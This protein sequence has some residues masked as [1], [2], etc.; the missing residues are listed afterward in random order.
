M[1]SITRPVDIFEYHSSLIDSHNEQIDHTGYGYSHGNHD[2]SKQT[3]SVLDDDL[4]LKAVSR[5]PQRRNSNIIG[6]KFHNLFD[7]L[8]RRSRRSSFND[9][10]HNN[11]NLK[12][13]GHGGGHGNVLADHND[14]LKQSGHGGG[15][16]NVL[17]DHNDNLKQSGHGGGHGNVLAD[18][19]D[20]LKQSGHGGG[21][22][23]VLADHN[24]NL[25]QSGHGGGHGNVLADHND[26]LKQSGPGG[27]HG[28]ILTDHNDNLKQSGHG[29]GHGNVLA[30]HNDNLKQ[31]GH[32]G[33][34][35][36]VL[37]DHSDN[38]KQSGHGGG[39][40]NVLA[41]HNGD[42]MQSGLKIIES[43]YNSSNNIDSNDN[44]SPE[45]E[46]D[47]IFN[48]VQAQ[49][50][51]VE[52]I[53]K[54]KGSSSFRRQPRFDEGDMEKVPD[55]LQVPV[56]VIEDV[57]EILVDQ[58]ET[59][60]LSDS[61]SDESILSDNQSNDKKEMDCV[62]TS[63]SNEE[64]ANNNRSNQSTTSDN[65]SDAGTSSNNQSNSATNRPDQ[66]NNNEKKEDAPP[67]QSKDSNFPTIQSHKGCLPNS[68]SNNI[69]NQTIQS[70]DDIHATDQ[71]DHE[72][73]EVDVLVNRTWDTINVSI[74][75]FLEKYQNL[76]KRPSTEWKTI[77]I[78]ISSTFTDFFVEREII[79]KRIMPEL[80]EWADK[81][82]VRIVECDLRWGVPANTD[83]KET[84]GIMMD[85]LDRCIEETNG[86]PFFVCLLGDRYGWVPTRKYVSQ[87]IINQFDWVYPTSMT[88]MEIIHGALRTNSQNALF[89]MREPSSLEGIPESYQPLYRDRSLLAKQSIKRLKSEL[90]N[91]FPGQ[92]FDYSS[93][94]AGVDKLT[95]KVAF[96]HLEDF[97]E[98]VIK[99][100]KEK[101]HDYIKENFE[102]E[103]EC[104]TTSQDIFIQKRGEFLLGR[105]KELRMLQEFSD[106]EMCDDDLDA[107]QRVLFVVAPSGMGKSSLMARYVQQ[108]QKD[109]I[110]CAWNFTSSSQ[111]T[112]SS[113]SVLQ[114]L[115]ETLG[116]ILKVKLPQTGDQLIHDY[117]ALKNYF[118]K[119]LKEISKKHPGFIIIIDAINQFKDNWGRSG[120]WLP[121]PSDELNIKYVISTTPNTQDN[122]F[123]ILMQK[124]FKISETFILPGLNK[125]TRKQMIQTY[126]SKFNKTLDEEQS[127]IIVSLPEAFS[128]LFLTIA[129]EETRIFGIFENLTKHVKKLPGKIPD[130]I[131]FVFKRLMKEDETHLV[132]P[133]LCLIYCSNSG[134]TESELRK[135][136][137]PLYDDQSFVE[138]LP[139][140]HWV[141]IYRQLKSFLI[142]TSNGKDE[143]FYFFHSSVEEVNSSDEI[144]F[145]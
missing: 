88:H 100:L 78:F 112:T 144:E 140:M 9:V 74:P 21:H 90:R 111:R 2:S 121:L 101:I 141:K 143:I 63:Q 43:G 60:D 104:L 33:G 13:S 135:L 137:A 75:R 108:L 19:N 20:N 116:R 50:D 54:L 142:S 17:A 87:D 98:I 113:S 136:L 24:D 73:S 67:N 80:Q 62:T 25:K 79:I 37:S 11:D 82:K 99:F 65:Q 85:E 117:N 118:E 58:S 122:N 42:S 39:H 30:D 46:M 86:K 7:S 83:F 61:Q 71:S 126:F 51:Q 129:C 102:N 127:E 125:A 110:P 5:I 66:S 38:L 6:E 45:N 16:G 44:I 35:G 1:S 18:H 133:T 81:L 105:D 106:A 4:S 22:G 72:I 134:L 70:N 89:M 34:H 52:P 57:D 12:Q 15:H 138:L 95:K 59:K 23:N 10:N 145:S 91:T 41:D 132:E 29:G 77:R 69:A 27:G 92:T 68:Q 93:E 49:H 84:I 103:T 32:G 36:N 123:S 115:C 3:K 119:L 28:N 31:S 130:L 97:E 48:S 53:R 94:V 131:S 14:N 107:A 55:A 114:H 64:A 56:I 124:F 96:N 120:A 47:R 128:P 139:K 26:N 109:G 8:K 76:P 40:G